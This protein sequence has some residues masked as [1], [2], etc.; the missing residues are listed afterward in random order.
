MAT[1][2]NHKKTAAQSPHRWLAGLMSMLTV[3]LGWAWS[4]AAATV[5]TDKPDYQPGNIFT[6]NGSGFHPNETVT[7]QVA[8]LDGLAWQHGTPWT[9]MTDAKGSFAS[10]TWVVP[11]EALNRKFVLKADCQHLVGSDTAHISTST[12]FTDSG[13][14]VGNVAIGHQSPLPVPAN[15]TVQ[16]AI[17][18][19]RNAIN[20]SSGNFAVDLNISG[21]PSGVQ[22]TPAGFLPYNMSFPNKVFT[23]TLIVT[24]SVG[25]VADGS[26]P[27]TVTATQTSGNTASVSAPGVL[28]VGSSPIGGPTAVDDSAFTLKNTSVKID[29]RAND[30]PPL[31]T[32]LTIVSVTDPATGTA[33]LNSDNTVTYDPANNAD[34]YSDFFS[35]TIQDSAGH[36][37]TANV[38][39]TVGAFPYVTISP[40]YATAC[41]GSAVTITATGHSGT[42]S[43]YTFNWSTGA[44]DTGVA[45][46]S[47]TVN[48]S[49]N[50][51][52]TATDGSSQVS[53]PVFSVVTLST[54]T[55]PVPDN[56]TL[57]TVTSQCSADL[58]TAPTATDS[59][60]TKITGV[61][62]QTGPFGQ[63]D[64]LITWTYTDGQ[65][66]HSSQTQNVSVQNTLQPVPD[67]ESLS[68]VTKQSPSS[69]PFTGETIM[70]QLGLSRR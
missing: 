5:T 31:P 63:G 19:A 41:P 21:L 43:T 66:R 27:F 28:V 45:Q 47:I 37:S 9:V 17:T 69:N 13:T 18:V 48:A 60:G 6:A 38:N 15:S 65:G 61:P 11:Q 10:S 1:I 42:S 20:G 29:V 39:V 46:S 55:A 52:V 64:Y 22:V 53:A 34:D 16:F 26:Y 24:M 3:L 62:D 49:G 23:Q 32:L 70:N 14:K 33:T 56:A 51:Y 30:Q 36:Q 4:G 35:Y 50:Y 58:P 59:C 68:Q 25:N 67:A 7:L 57:N 2:G 12:T 8:V 44:S 40:D 54:A